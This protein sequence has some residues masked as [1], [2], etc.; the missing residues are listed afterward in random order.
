MEG[1]IVSHSSTMSGPRPGFL[2]RGCRGRDIEWTKGAAFDGDRDEYRSK[3][4]DHSI[5]Y[6]A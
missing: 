2:G 5:Y 6:A 1:L 3:D 4:V